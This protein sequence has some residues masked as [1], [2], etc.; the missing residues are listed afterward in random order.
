MKLLLDT[1]I[2]LWFISSDRRLSNT[3]IEIIRNTD[4]DV[5][6]SIISIWEATI[7]YQLGKLTLPQSP[8]IY[9]P[10]QRERHLITSLPLTE[11][12]VVQLSKLPN[13]H[14][15]P[16]DRM[17]ICQALQHDLTIVTV[18]DAIRAYPVKILN[19]T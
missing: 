10:I 3:F 8:E 2:F 19:D 6:L 18:D 5:Y 7:K 1:H 9:L 13:I 14:R 17:L 4:N 15:D 12:S 11:D 16:F